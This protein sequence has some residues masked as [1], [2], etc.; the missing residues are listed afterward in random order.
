MKLSNTY[1]GISLKDIE[2][3]MQNKEL[4][5]RQS[6][7][8]DKINYLLNRIKSMNINSQK[9]E[10]DK[11]KLLIKIK[12]LE[13]ELDINKKKAL[14]DLEQ[15]R[16]I[17]TQLN[18]KIM[19]LN[20]LLNEKEKSIFELFNQLYD[21]R[22]QLEKLKYKKE[23]TER[24]NKNMNNNLLIENKKRIAKLIEENKNFRNISQKLKIESQKMKNYYISHLHEQRKSFEIQKNEFQNILKDLGYKL[25]VLKNENNALKNKIENVSI[26]HLPKNK[27]MNDNENMNDQL[28]VHLKEENDILKSQLNENGQKFNDNNFIEGENDLREI[29]YLKNEL[30]EKNNELNNL[31]E[32]LN[33]LIN[34]LNSF[35]NNNED[36]MNNNTQLKQELE[37]LNIKVFNLENNNF[38]KV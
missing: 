38:N 2:L 34:Q 36:L 12:S 25:N 3:S 26:N 7:L 24:D 16:N 31:K 27:D 18:E 30:E 8:A 17:I 14:K 32:K 33:N 19:N 15:K 28:L 20:A 22:E 23:N 6:K 35:K 13:N 11:K 4:R 37:Q 10:N 21:L 1:A 5:R 29:Y 9:E